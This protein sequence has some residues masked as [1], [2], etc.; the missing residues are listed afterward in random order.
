MS[1]FMEP[2]PGRC[3]GSTNLDTRAFM[4]KWRKQDKKMTT[5][6][7]GMAVAVFLVAVEESLGQT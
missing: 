4:Q 2:K 1:G 7:M 3:Q 6:K 5:R